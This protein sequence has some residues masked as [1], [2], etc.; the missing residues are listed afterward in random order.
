MKNLTLFGLLLLPLFLFA[1]NVPQSFKY[2]AIFRDAD[3]VEA[4]NMSISVQFQIY[5][6]SP[7]GPEVYCE[8]HQTTTNSFG[9]FSL[10]V[11]SSTQN[12]GTT[13][14]EDI[15]WGSDDHYLQVSIRTTGDFEP[16]G[17]PVQF[18]REGAY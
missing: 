5:R 16:Y 4:D 13:D 10:N 11:G 2:Q 15:D 17:E 18:C 1:Q 8:E 14:F 9:L 6:E 12:C 3:G 7:N